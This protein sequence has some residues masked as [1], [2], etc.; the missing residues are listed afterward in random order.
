MTDGEIEPTTGAEG[1]HAPPGAPWAEGGDGGS[2]G[3]LPGFSAGNGD[4]GAAPAAAFD[5]IQRPPELDELPSW[6]TDPLP[7]APGGA[8]ANGAA[9]ADGPP[10]A[11]W[12]VHGIPD[13]GAD[14]PSPGVPDGGADWPSPGPPDNGADWPSPGTA[15]NGASTAAPGIPDGGR[16]APPAGPWDPPSG[17][18]PS[19][20]TPADSAYRLPGAGDELRSLFGEVVGGEGDGTPPALGPP[21]PGVDAR[22]A[23]DHDPLGPPQARPPIDLSQ[24]D[25]PLGPAPYLPPGSPPP[26]AAPSPAARVGGHTDD[27]PAPTRLP[28]RGDPHTWTSP[29][30]RSAPEAPARLPRAGDLGDEPGRP[31]APPARVRGRWRRSP[32]PHRPRAPGPRPPDRQPSPSSS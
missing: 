2:I 29:A 31:R 30:A 14:W 23:P 5:A 15:A 22:Q 6:Y 8:P 10:S 21:G 18:A 28:R 7:N 13:S 24:L 3:D 1:Q 17:A 4:H 11:P 25:R 12:A 9:S 19:G 27:R 32:V 16:P 26:D 20:G